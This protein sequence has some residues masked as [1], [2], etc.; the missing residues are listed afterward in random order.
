[1]AWCGALAFVS[2]QKL[3]GNRPPSTAARFSTG[4]M[5]YNDSE[6][7]K[8]CE[9]QGLPGGAGTQLAVALIRNPTGLYRPRKLD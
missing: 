3:V 5:I 2:E 9:V 7:V 4:L 1:M 8:P 6:K